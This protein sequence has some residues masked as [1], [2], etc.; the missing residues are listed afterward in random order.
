MLICAGSG[1]MLVSA[2]VHG[3]LLVIASQ[4]FTLRS[5]SPLY[6][7]VGGMALCGFMAGQLFVS[8]TLNL[9]SWG[10]KKK[11]ICCE[12]CSSN[13]SLLQYFVQGLRSALTVLTDSCCLALL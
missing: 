8:C 10:G 5:L 1:T 6:L 13:K 3:L 4:D 7:S 9:A 11:K 2:V 12:S